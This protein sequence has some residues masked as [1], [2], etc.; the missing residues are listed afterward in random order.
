MRLQSARARGFADHCCGLILLAL[1]GAMPL[2]RAQPLR[3]RAG[4]RMSWS[5]IGRHLGKTIVAGS[6]P[7]DGVARI[8]RGTLYARHIGRTTLALTTRGGGQVKVALTVT[9]GELAGTV[10]AIYLFPS[11]MAGGIEPNVNTSWDLDGNSWWMSD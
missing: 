2:A 6:A 9:P 11:G 5:D 10:G 4:Q 1:L 7:R 8:E 3:L